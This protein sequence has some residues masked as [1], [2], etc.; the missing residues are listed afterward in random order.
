MDD[1]NTKTKECKVKV[2]EG[3]VNDASYKL[4]SIMVAIYQK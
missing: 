3:P 2:Y 4:A 1:H